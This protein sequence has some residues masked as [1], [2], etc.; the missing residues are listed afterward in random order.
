MSDMFIWRL[1]RPARNGQESSELV[2]VV[3]ETDAEARAIASIHAGPRWIWQSEDLV[4]N[5]QLGIVTGDWTK[6]VV[7]R[8]YNE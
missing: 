2:V 7:C 8:E 3:A 5:N 1:H 6:G 4:T